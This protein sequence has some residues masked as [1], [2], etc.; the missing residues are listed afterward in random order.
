[1][2]QPD[3]HIPAKRYFIREVQTYEVLV[4]D[5][6]NLESEATNV[7]TDFSVAAACIPVAVALTVTLL[8]VSIQNIKLFESFFCVTF[9]C[10]AMGIIYGFKAWR[11]RGHFTKAMQRIRDYQMPPLGEKDEELAPSELQN[12]PSE[13]EGREGKQ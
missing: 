1:M 3:P 8:T 4:T 13:E 7:G 12:L 2:N 10:W 6:N 9:L 11:G 5:F